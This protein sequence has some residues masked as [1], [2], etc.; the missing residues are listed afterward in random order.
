MFK[1][2][3]VCFAF[4]FS[5]FS[6]SAFAANNCTGATYYDA[7]SDTCIAC[8]TGYD[9]NT[10]AGKTSVSQCQI[11]CPAGTWNGE[12][13]Q[14]EYLESDR[15][16]YIDTNYI[17]S[18]DTE[19][20]AVASRTKDVTGFIYGSSYSSQSVWFTAYLD[21]AGYWR[22]GN[23]KKII[24]SGTYYPVDTI[25][26]SVQNKFGIWIDGK[27][28]WTYSNVSNFKTRSSLYVFSANNG[29]SGNATNGLR[30]YSFRINENGTQYMNLVPAR[31]NS[32][33]VLGM[34]DTVTGQFFANAGSGTFTAGPDVGGWC[35]DV[36]AGYWAAASVTNYG[37]TGTR[38]ACPAGTYTVGYGHGAD[39]ANDCGRILH[40]GDSVIYTRKN[41]P[42]TPALNI[43]MDNGDM[44]YIGLSTTDHTVSRLHF[45]TGETKYTAFD[46]SLFY[47]ERDY[48]TGEKITQ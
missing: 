21:P 35:T 22:V 30:I 25:H 44:Y 36:G 1:R 14:L 6:V 8:P 40:L 39:E 2:I 41:K 24:N 16:S 7:D 28:I 43:R 11:S 20:I 37:S 46:D 38:N 45:Q 12:Y 27:Q 26:E 23:G 10:D 42:T 18:Q 4:I 13:T 33:D 31:R 3:G 9:Y 32:D 17:A 34:Y 29:S 5:I 19:V 15:N 48:D 47:G